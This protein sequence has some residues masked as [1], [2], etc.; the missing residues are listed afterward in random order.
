METLP[1]SRC[2]ALLIA[3]DLPLAAVIAGLMAEIGLTREE[4]TTAALDATIAGPA[5]H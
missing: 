5:R 4:A 2:A 3:M 1:G